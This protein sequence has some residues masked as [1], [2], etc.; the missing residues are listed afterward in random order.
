VRARHAVGRRVGPLI[1]DHRG[2]VAARRVASS[3]HACLRRGAAAVGPAKREAEAVVVGGPDRGLRDEVGERAADVQRVASSER[4]V[5]RVVAPCADTDGGSSAHRRA[6]LRRTVA[7][8][9]ALLFWRRPGPVFASPTEE[10]QI[11]AWLIGASSTNI[12]SPLVRAW[13]TSTT[14]RTPPTGLGQCWPPA[15]GGMAGNGGAGGAGGAEGGDGG[16]WPP[17]VNVN[18]ATAVTCVRPAT[19]LSRE[20]LVWPLVHVVMSQSQSHWQDGARGVATERSAS[21]AR[22]QRSHPRTVRRRRA[23]YRVASDVVLEVDCAASWRD[24]ALRLRDLARAVEE[25]AVVV[26]T[27]TVQARLERTLCRLGSCTDGAVVACCAAHGLQPPMSTPST[28]MAVTRSDAEPRSLR[29]I[30]TCTLY[31]EPGIRSTVPEADGLEK[32]VVP[33]E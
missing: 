4:V 28:R 11:H 33:D 12:I 8:A 1:V 32:A 9:H 10:L 14:E 23:T 20:Q 21:R 19:V 16:E 7:R 17:R 6:A 26:A 3:G 13:L 27:V 2:D 18:R 31:V 25:R 30:S 29:R 5:A 24:D 15:I 22:A